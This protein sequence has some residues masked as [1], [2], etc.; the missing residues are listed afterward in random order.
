MTIWKSALNRR[1]SDFCH[2][3]LALM[4]AL[5]T[6]A[7]AQARFEAKTLK[8]S[9]LAQ[10]PPEQ[11]ESAPLT[12]TLRDALD[13]ARKY[14]A[15]FV[16]ALND[17]QI[18]GQD[19]VL[20]RAALL[21]SLS[22]RTEYLN[23]Q[24]NGVIPTGRYVTNDGVHVYRQWG[25]LHQDFSATALTRVE[26][27]RAVAK[28]AI[29]RAK[30]EVASRGLVVTVTKA[31]YALIVARRKYA[32]AQESLEQANRL[33]R[34]S[35]QL[36]SGGEVAT[37]DVL[38]FRLQQDAQ[39]RAFRE[40]TLAM[41]Q[42]QLD[43]AVLLFPNFDQHFDI[44]DDL[45]LPPALP[46]LEEIRVLAS[47]NNP[48]LRVAIETER[49]ARL[50]VSA[51]TQA[52]LPTVTVDVDYGIEANRFAFRSRVAADPAAGRLPNV[53]YF[54]TATMT[55]PVWDW[56]ATRAK[57]KQAEIKRA[58]ARIELSQT[59]REL[60]RN[61]YGFYEEAETS[62]NELDSL[63]RSADEAAESL[64]LSLLRYQAGEAT[65]LEVVDAQNTLF[66]SHNAFDDGAL[67]YSVA[68]ANLQTLTGQ[69]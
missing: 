40:A 69:F 50:G 64:R 5:V 67:R 19:R 6:H 57:L 39:D 45:N 58:Q 27:R 20:A 44:V 65:V 4:C 60:L 34:I 35:Q 63:R 3:V 41:D 31:Y 18:A 13:R 22:D 9:I 55:F 8:G 29:A 2:V 23:T 1:T 38:K 21:P 30:A 24:G 33:L 11:T 53:G 66:Q 48:D 36:E 26:Y 56:G 59:Q 47:R 10:T 54:M 14:N 51:A 32:T 37:S 17:A 12:L 61:V 52:F 49:A 43:L 62:H 25:V 46:S 42:A 28:E 68:V 15:Q 7:T 16:S